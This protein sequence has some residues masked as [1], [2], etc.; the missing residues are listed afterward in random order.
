MVLTGQAHGKL[1][2]FGEHA[3]VHGFPATGLTLPLRTCI[4]LSC[5]T[6]ASSTVPN[7]AEVVKPLIPYMGPEVLGLWH[8]HDWHVRVES[9]IPMGGGLGSSAALTGALAHALAQGLP[10][11]PAQHIGRMAH[12]AERHFHGHPSGVDTALALGQGLVTFKRVTTS[13]LKTESCDIGP[14]AMVVGVLPRT[15]TTRD[16]VDHVSHQ[17]KTKHDATLSVL[18]ELGDLAVL[19][20]VTERAWTVLG[21]RANQAQILL[22]R[23]GLST[24][25]LDRTLAAGLAAGAYGGKLSGAGGGG[26]FVLFCQD[27][28][29]AQEVA[30]AVASDRAS[31]QSAS[32]LQA[33]IYSWDEHTLHASDGTTG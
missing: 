22:K 6:D 10:H 20:S 5:D 8:E 1:L 13:I 3:V 23:L 11:L 2:L 14:F 15:R 28:D 19:P 29:S 17:L 27:R 24:S 31:E 30:R 32:P 18:S 9:D 33:H 16:L 4:H 12:Q 25:T 26:A 7:Q 21:D